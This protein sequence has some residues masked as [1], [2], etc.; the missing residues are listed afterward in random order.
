MASGFGAHGYTAL[1]F[2]PRCCCYLLL[3][4]LPV[5]A[6]AAG[7]A[8]AAAA[9]GADP[10]SEGV[11]LS[12]DTL[13]GSTAAPYNLGKADLLCFLGVTG[14]CQALSCQASRTITRNLIALL[15]LACLQLHC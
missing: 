15:L 1:L 12:F 6:G 4:L 9:G 7:A 5:V 10:T 2:N 14:Q 11:V 8:D 13:P 3:L